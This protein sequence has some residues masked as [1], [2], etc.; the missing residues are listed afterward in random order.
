MKHNKS[1]PWE[2]LPVYTSIF[3]ITILY[4]LIGCIDTSVKTP[5]DYVYK[6]DFINCTGCADCVAPCP[7]AAIEII[8]TDNVIRAYIDPEKCIGCGECF[9]YCE[10]NAIEKVPK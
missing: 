4:M 3:L 7:E 8:E 1:I 5:G 2:K 10:L 6:A 9:F